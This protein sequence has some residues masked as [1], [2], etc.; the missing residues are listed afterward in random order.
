MGLLVYAKGPQLYNLS[1]WAF[2]LNTRCAAIDLGFVGYATINRLVNAQ[3]YA[4][5]ARK[6]DN[7]PSLAG[8]LTADYRGA[9]IAAMWFSIT[10]SVLCATNLTKKNM[11][12]LSP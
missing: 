4:L 11:M 3:Q 9:I 6:T 1:D 5:F 10:G 12:R 2:L 7:S 8:S